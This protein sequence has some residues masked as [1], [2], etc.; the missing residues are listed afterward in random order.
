[1][2]EP[3]D[4]YF[5]AN[6]PPRESQHARWFAENVQPHDGM[7]RAWLHSRF[8]GETDIDDIVQETYLRTW[9][10]Q[11]AGKIGSAKAFVFATARNLAV[12]R[13]RHRKVTR[14]EPLVENT[15]LYVLDDDEGIPAAVERHQELELL[16]EAIQSLPDRCRRIFTLRKVYGLSQKE[17]AAQLGISENTVSAQLTIGVK[18]CMEFMLRYRRER[19]GRWL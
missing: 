2:A 16:T 15:E 10:A 13:L 12:D 18:K 7:L 17:I 6:V 1:M 14:S 8:P 3:I 11:A 4:A 19:E 5:P 9:Q